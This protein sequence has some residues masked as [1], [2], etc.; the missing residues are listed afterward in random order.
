RGDYYRRLRGFIHSAL[1]R[2]TQGLGFWGRAL[3]LRDCFLPGLELRPCLA[4]GI[5]GQLAARFAQHAHRL[6]G[7]D[8]VL[9]LPAA[10]PAQEAERT[11]VAVAL[12]RSRLTH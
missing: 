2:A 5:P 11:G 1:P 7:D 12:R 9:H 3:L 6:V 4:A 10:L 8:R